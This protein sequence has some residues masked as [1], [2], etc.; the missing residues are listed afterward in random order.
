MGDIKSFALVSTALKHVSVTANRKAWDCITDDTNFFGEQEFSLM[1]IESGGAMGVTIT[2][3]KPEDSTTH[4]V[5]WQNYVD[6]KRGMAT[7]INE[8]TLPSGLKVPNGFA[9]N[10]LEWSMSDD[11]G[12]ITNTDIAL[13]A[14]N[15]GQQVV[16]SIALPHEDQ[17]KLLVELNALLA[18]VEWK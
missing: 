18:T 1:H 12:P 5:Y 16:I 15:K 11:G 9:G 4:A 8:V 13:S 7:V 17:A 10:G 6:G 3:K 14:L 2:E